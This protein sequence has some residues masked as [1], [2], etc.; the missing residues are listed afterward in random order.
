MSRQD[1]S[2]RKTP[3]GVDYDAMKGKLVRV[4]P[5]IVPEKLL[6][7]IPDGTDCLTGKLVWVCNFTICLELPPR[8]GSE[9][10]PGRRLMINKGAMAAIE[11]AT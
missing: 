1:Q 4:W 10:A 3:E 8:Y 9:G 11:L 7:C 5:A 6:K 2:P